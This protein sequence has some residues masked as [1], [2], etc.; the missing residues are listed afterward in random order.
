MLFSVVEAAHH[1]ARQAVLALEAN[2]EIL[3]GDD[4]EDEPAGP[5]RLDLV[6]VLA[7]GTGSRCFDDAVVLRA[8]RVGKND[9]TAL[10]MIDGI[11]VL[12]LTFRYQA[13]RGRWIGG[14]DQADL[15][16]LVIM[17]AKQEEAPILGRAQTQKETGIILRMDEIIGPVGA[18]CVPQH[19]AWTVV[20]I[21]PNIEKRTAVGRPFERSIVVGDA[22][23]D[24]R[25]AVGF[26][27]VDRVE[28]R[29]LGIHGV[30]NEA[31]IGAVSDACDA[32]ISVRLCQRVPVHQHAP[33]AAVARPAAK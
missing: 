16:R 18:N 20:F 23:I 6:P 12:R 28:L 4:I 29:A 3:E 32:E 15:C 24:H 19:T 25:A 17:N 30:G 13:R 10:V 31:V 1:D 8:I 27:D 2:E 7:A 5:V 11:V 33:L 14:I 26:D 21:K 9:E 22:R